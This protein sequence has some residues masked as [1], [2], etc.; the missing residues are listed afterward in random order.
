[1]AATIVIIAVLAVVVVFAIRGSRKHFEGEGGCCGGGGGTIEDIKEL[2]GKKLG[3]KIV[4]ID[5]MHCE[6]CKNRVQRA[7]NRIDGAAAKVDLKK[8]E[9]VVSYDRTVSDDAI[10]KAVEDEDYKVVSIEDHPAA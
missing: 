9:A 8:K 1:M 5:G 10:R 2:E 4:K 3:E 7:I 6:N